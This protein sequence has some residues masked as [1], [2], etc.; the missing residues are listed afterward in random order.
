MNRLFDDNN[1]DDFVERTSFDIGLSNNTI[2]ELNKLR[3]LLNNYKE[4]DTD[5]EVINDTEWEKIV[6]QAQT[7]IKKWT[8]IK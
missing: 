2:F 5:E 6:I 3:E 1:F 8:K 7:V 4:K